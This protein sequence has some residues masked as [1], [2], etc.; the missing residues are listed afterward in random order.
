[1]V[2]GGHVNTVQYGQE[3]EGLPRAS[4][5]AGPG[6]STTNQKPSLSVRGSQT[7]GECCIKTH[8]CHTVDGTETVEDN[9]RVSLG[10][11]GWEEPTTEALW[12]WVSQFGWVSQWGGARGSHRRLLSR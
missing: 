6:E 9:I 5:H 4:H 2:G 1:M 10:E 12:S 8:K 7:P 11:S 3:E